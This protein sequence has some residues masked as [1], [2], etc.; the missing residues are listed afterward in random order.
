[1]AHTWGIQTARAFQ[2]QG[3]PLRIYLPRALATYVLPSLEG[4]ARTLR[5]VW[6]AQ[7]A[8]RRN[9]PGYVGK[10]VKLAGSQRTAKLE[11]RTSGW[12]SGRTPDSVQGP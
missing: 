1:M 2:A 12:L 5:I 9:F 6:Y 4:Y 3:P 10:R 8:I 7:E 11:W